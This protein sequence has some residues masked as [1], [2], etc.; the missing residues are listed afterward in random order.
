MSSA[1]SDEV[2]SPPPAR[3]A[4]AILIGL[5][6]GTTGCKAVFFSEEGAVLGSAYREY[7][8]ETDRSGKAEQNAERVWQLVCEGLR[9]AAAAAGTGR[10]RPAVA[11]LSLSVQGDAIIP[12]DGAGVPVHPAILGMDYRSAPQARACEERFGGEAL[13]LRTGMRPHAINSL[14]KVLWLRQE[15]PEAWAR[16]R[17]ITTYADFILGR[18]GAPGVIDRTMASRTMAW[19]LAR[20]AWATD[21][22][23]ELG[24]GRSLLS[25]PVQ[26]GSAVGRL[27]PHLARQ[28]GIEGTPILV[29]GAHDQP[30]GAVGAGVLDDGDAVISTG[31]AEV[32]STVFSSRERAISLYSGYYPCYEAALPGRWF[33]FALNH[34][35]GLLLRWY[36]DT[37]AA[38]EVQA[39]Q[40]TGRDPYEIILSG[41]PEGPS[42][43]LFLPHL[44][45]AGTPSCDPDSRGAIVGLTLASTRSDVVKAILDCQTY[46]LAIN[47]EALRGA[48]IS[49]KWMSAVGGGA[50]SSVWLQV[51]ADVLGIPIRTLQVPEAACLGA[52]VFAGT[53]AG[54]FESVHA[55]ARRTV[56]F[57]RVYEPDP[58]SHM[59]H[60]A[61]LAVYRE[62]HPALRPIHQRL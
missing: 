52:A 17:R 29:T 8:I 21:L 44:N 6:V 27:K 13:F 49:V 31:T 40:S 37:W 59:A 43:L 62:L 38:V 56:R 28:L 3:T 18:L 36:R 20:G 25:D 16:T 19:D 53:G 41:L 22:L 45:G 5:D 47:L 23:Q 15:R 32:L 48:G 7:G 4:E 51:K 2:A 1:R 12:L 30:A 50:R 58:A 39:A 46:E 34:V 57:A 26:T 60:A 61:R 9:E 55:G 54:V 11:S 35:G 10:Q 24:I 33:T 14:C 42:P